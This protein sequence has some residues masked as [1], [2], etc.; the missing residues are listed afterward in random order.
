MQPAGGGSSTRLVEVE[1][2]RWRAAD[3]SGR[4]TVIRPP[5]QRHGPP[6]GSIAYGPGGLAGVVPEPMTVEAPIR[7]TRLEAIRRT[8]PQ[9]VFRAVAD[10]YAWHHPDSRARATLLRLLCNADG[11]DGPGAVTG[12]G[13]VTDRAGRAG[14]AVSVDS[15]HGATRDTVIVDPGTGL[16][17]AHETV[18]M[19][20]PA[21]LAVATPT[22]VSYTL[23]LDRGRRAQPGPP[24]RQPE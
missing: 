12:R 14:L 1:E 18:R 2:R 17:L 10:V 7:A 6:A 15:D 22:L 11:L 4:V 13:P 20:N 21:G 8:G 5:G 3:G 16:L 24:R 23:Y 9:A 19:R